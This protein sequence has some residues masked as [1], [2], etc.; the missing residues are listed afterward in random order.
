MVLL[1][2]KVLEKIDN[3]KVT[4]RNLKC[5]TKYFFAEAFF[6]ERSLCEWKKLCLQYQR[7]VEVPLICRNSSRKRIKGDF[8]DYF[9]FLVA[10]MCFATLAISCDNLTCDNMINPD[11]ACSHLMSDVISHTEYHG[12]E[13]RYNCQNQKC[14]CD[15]LIV[16]SNKRI[17]FNQI[18]SEL[19]MGLSL[20]FSSGFRNVCI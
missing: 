10:L 3:S 1:F 11:V 6:L 13:W 12:N 16:W 8:L 20:L 19:Q 5:T 7:K 15:L 9:S 17:W 2:Q 14:P 18:I 4:L